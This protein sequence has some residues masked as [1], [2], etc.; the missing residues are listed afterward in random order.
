MAMNY[1][2]NNWLVRLGLWRG[3]SSSKVVNTLKSDGI[4]LTRPGFDHNGG[5]LID[6]TSETSYDP[7]DGIFEHQISWW[8]HTPYAGKEHGS[9][10]KHY[11]LR[12][13]GKC[14]DDED[15]EVENPTIIPDQIWING[16]PVLVATGSVDDAEHQGKYQRMVNIAWDIS[17][18]V[19]VLLSKKDNLSVSSIA[20]IFSDRTNNLSKEIFG[21]MPSFKGLNKETGGFQ[22]NPL[23]LAYTKSSLRDDGK[24]QFNQC[25]DEQLKSLLGFRFNNLDDNLAHIDSSL[26]VAADPNSGEA[27]KSEVNF[28]IDPETN[29]RVFTLSIAPID[30]PEGHIVPDPFELLR[31]EFSKPDDNTA[32]LEKSEFMQV[33]KPVTSIFEEMEKIGLFQDANINHIAKGDY[34]PYQDLATKYRVENQITEMPLPPKLKGYG[35]EMVWIPLNGSSMKKK[36]GL[37]T[38]GIGGGNLFISRGLKDDGSL[39]EVSVLLGM[40]FIPAS[41][42]DDFDGILADITP[43]WKDVRYVVIDHDHFDHSSIEAYV[44]KGFFKPKKNEMQKE[45]ICT[46]EVRYTMEKRFNNVGVKKEYWPKFKIV[47]AVENISVKD[48]DDNTRMW[49]QFC[50]NGVV[51]S[52]LTSTQIITGCYKDE[53][54]HE[55]YFFTNDSFAL[56]TRGKEF[57]RHGTR[58]LAAEKEVTSS[59]VDRDLDVAVYEPTGVV[60][61]GNTTTVE[62]FKNSWRSVLSVLK[63]ENKASLFVPFS[64]NHLEYQGLI[65]LFSEPEAMR[66]YT[67]VGANAEHRGMTLNKFG[68][69]PDVDLTKVKLPQEILDEVLEKLDLK[70]E[71]K[72]LI[73]LYEGEGEDEDEYEYEDEDEFE[74]E[75]LYED[76]PY[77]KALKKRIKELKEE[78]LV[79]DKKP[80][81]ST[82]IY[83]LKK[84]LKHGGFKFPHNSLY[85]HNMYQA[86]F[87]HGFQKEAVMNGSRTSNRAKAF[88][89]NPGHFAAFTTGPTGTQDEHFAS[90]S[91]YR[92]FWS[93]FDTDDKVRNTGFYLDSKDS[94]ICVPQAAPPIEGAEDAQE[95]LMHDLVNKRDVTVVCAFR[96]GFKIYNPKTAT[97]KFLDKF[98]EDGFNARYD[99]ANDQIVVDDQ[100]AHIHGHGSRNDL[101]KMISEINA[102]THEFGHIP[103]MKHLKEAQ[104]IVAE[105]GKH[106]SINDPDDHV[107]RKFETDPKT[108]EVS[109]PI[110]AYLQQSFQVLRLIYQFGRPWR[111]VVDLVKHIVQRTDGKTRL[112]GLDLRKGDDDFERNNAVTNFNDAV[113]P[114]KKSTCEGHKSRKYEP[115][116]VN[117]KPEGQRPP[118][119]MT[120]GRMRRL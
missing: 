65:E 8:R 104:D 51:H 112:A 29:N 71:E 22:E 89:K 120:F 109:L 75:E 55:S 78:F 56:S 28:K 24:V 92:D 110:K 25:D 101:K 67:F 107:A 11:V 87:V 30:V 4:K 70:E 103:T 57:A 7:E 53:K 76:T 54:Y 93:L 58:G 50:K 96:N 38:D 106:T 98:K 42:S 64:T 16:Q 18:Q 63:D 13:K 102:K 12:I 72:F 73:D 86:I 17:N 23:Q 14:P 44:Q 113:N 10:N 81:A 118:G 116:E 26:V 33:P 119:R 85:D 90:L 6:V 47:D 46:D 108:G 80:E 15:P 83:I 79:R 49:I 34:P 36:G 100:P 99:A 84:I 59:K 62:Q 97:N 95:Q 105:L 9:D 61:G 40:P 41:A 68:V 74:A 82:E 91:R 114:N 60:S 48:A 115:S 19:N 88:R 69:N 52:A 117:I 31:L 21:T 32:V 94:V 66:N 3:S 27:F 1:S 5:Q 39:S 43:W 77:K 37:P 35:G 111:P 20:K 45:I 2:L